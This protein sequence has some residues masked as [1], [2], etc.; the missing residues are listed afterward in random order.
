L[1]RF[2]TRAAVW[3]VLAVSA[4]AGVMHTNADVVGASSIAQTLGSDA[5]EG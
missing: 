2:G 3:T 1:N 4:N 5:L